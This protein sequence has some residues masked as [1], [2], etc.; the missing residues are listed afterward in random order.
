MSRQKSNSVGG[1]GDP[2]SCVVSKSP[3]AAS[4]GRH[5]AHGNH[6][7]LH[8][9]SEWV[10][11]AVQQATI[12]EETRAVLGLSRSIVGLMA[13]APGPTPLG[14]APPLSVALQLD[15]HA[16]RVC[17]KTGSLHS[18]VD[19]PPL[20]TVSKS[21]RASEVAML[22]SS[23]SGAMYRSSIPSSNT[24]TKLECPW[25]RTR[26]LVVASWRTK[27]HA[28]STEPHTLTG[29]TG[30]TMWKA[31]LKQPLAAVVHTESSSTTAVAKPR[32]S[33]P[34]RL[35][36]SQYMKVFTTMKGGTA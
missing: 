20:K 2:R 35:S 23:W 16:A 28:S 8:A 7:M 13:D 9:G 15:G 1:S 34:S 10:S 24:V 26:W 4:T 5:S 21:D 25:R 14:V 3:S 31:M 29:H 19:E 6:I 22:C 27:P 17:S 18:A 32:G 12:E 33:I 36:R 30:G 11:R